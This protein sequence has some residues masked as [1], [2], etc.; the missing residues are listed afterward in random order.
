MCSTSV[1][2]AVG[3]GSG[4][5]A[6]RD[7]NLNTASKTEEH[8]GSAV[9]RTGCLSKHN[10]WTPYQTY[11]HIRLNAWLLP[12]SYINQ[13]EATSQCWPRAMQRG[14]NRFENLRRAL[15][16]YAMWAKAKSTPVM[17]VMRESDFCMKASITY[18]IQTCLILLISA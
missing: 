7:L 6:L 13:A 11:P 3:R 18:C 16:T 15:Q 10:R 1:N 5:H 9:A 4:H 2:R 17:I 14:S 12:P 8:C